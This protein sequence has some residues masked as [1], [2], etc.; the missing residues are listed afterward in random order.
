MKEKNA[1][2]FE[3]VVEIG[4]GADVHNDESNQPRVKCRR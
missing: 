3:Q 4:C 2:E 1:I